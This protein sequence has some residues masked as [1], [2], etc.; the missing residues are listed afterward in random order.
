[1]YGLDAPVLNVLAQAL[2][3][4]EKTRI[5]QENRLRQLT[6]DE[7]DKDGLER[8]FGLTEAHP[9]V[10]AL[11]AQVESL[12]TLE[13]GMTLALQRELRAHPLYPWI[14]EQVGLGKKQTA[15][16]LAAVGDPYWHPVHNRPRK[17]SELVAYAGYHN[18]PASQTV[19]DSQVGCAGGGSTSGSNESQHDPDAHPGRAFVAARRRKGQRV[20]WSTEAKTRVYLVAVSCIKQAGPTEKCPDR[21]VSPYR[22]VY[23]AARAKYAGLPISDLHAHNRALREVGRAVIKDLW[24][25]ARAVHEQHGEPAAAGVAA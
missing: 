12:K 6:R 1:M 23:D 20:N 24:R 11:A 9:A 14:K 18:V 8:G 15:R 3:D 17:V 19:T 2:D 5:A 22:P 16:L 10:R 21:R 7:P 4:A 13:H 25:Q